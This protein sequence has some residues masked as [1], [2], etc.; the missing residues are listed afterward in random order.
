[1]ERTRDKSSASSFTGQMWESINIRML[2]RKKE[3][4]FELL[5]EAKKLALQVIIYFFNLFI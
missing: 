5:E 3:L 1:M 2:G 4:L